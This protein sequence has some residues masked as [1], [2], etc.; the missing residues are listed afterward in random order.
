MN[1]QE[2]VK[3]SV[4]DDTGVVDCPHCGEQITV[5][6]KAIASADPILGL[7]VDV[8]IDVEP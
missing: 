6:A 5:R 8:E 3:E 2:S 7:S 4:L 1:E